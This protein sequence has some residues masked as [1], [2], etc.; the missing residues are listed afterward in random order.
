MTVSPLARSARAAAAFGLA[1]TVAG[2]A[3]VSPNA[4]LGPMPGQLEPIHAAAFTND[5]AVFWVSSNGCTGRED[6]EPIISRRGDEVIITLRRLTDD[7]CDRPM[8][9]GV[10]L[11]WSFEELGVKP[12]SSISVNNPYLLPQA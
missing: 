11:K 3:L 12:G 6:V 1:V 10:E 8:R 4:G 9:Q 5:L 2:C 7:T